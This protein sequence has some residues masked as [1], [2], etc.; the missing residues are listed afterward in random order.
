MAISVR[1]LFDTLYNVTG[2]SET[3]TSTTII[4]IITPSRR[5][6]YHRLWREIA[7]DYYTVNVIKIESLSPPPRSTETAHDIDPVGSDLNSSLCL[8]DRLASLYGFIPTPRKCSAVDVV[9]RWILT[10]S[11]RNSNRFDDCNEKRKNKKKKKNGKPVCSRRHN[12]GCDS[13]LRFRY[14]I[15]L[16]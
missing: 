6:R 5:R 7:S 14:W 1:V 16:Y 11:E 9:S 2:D 3:R 4:S 10:I 12:D 8:R 13:V 15:S